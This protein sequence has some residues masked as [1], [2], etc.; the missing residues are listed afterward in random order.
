VII[1]RVVKQQFY[2]HIRKRLEHMFVSGQIL[3]FEILD[4]GQSVVRRGNRDLVEHDIESNYVLY[5]VLVC[6]VFDLP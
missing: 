1:P 5:S 3:H 4:R 6:N 2:S